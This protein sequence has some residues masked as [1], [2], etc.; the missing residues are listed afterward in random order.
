[1]RRWLLSYQTGKNFPGNEADVQYKTDA[2][3]MEKDIPVTNYVIITA[4]I[5]VMFIASNC[6]VC[7]CL[8]Q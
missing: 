6:G 7:T 2:Y 3:F 1:M 5:F 8:C 4:I